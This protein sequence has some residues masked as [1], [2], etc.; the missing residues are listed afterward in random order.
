MSEAKDIKTAVLYGLLVETL[1]EYEYISWMLV[2]LSYT[3]KIWAVGFKPL[4]KQMNFYQSWL[5]VEIPSIMV[6][7]H[8]HVTH[9]WKYYPQNVCDMCS[10]NGSNASMLCSQT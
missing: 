2:M 9:T 6:S 4:I 5:C 8:T 3:Q 1:L 10:F 7:W